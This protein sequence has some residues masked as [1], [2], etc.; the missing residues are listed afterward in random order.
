MKALLIIGLQ[1]SYLNKSEFDIK[2]LNLILQSAIRVLEYFR[3]NRLPVFHIKSEYSENED[4]FIENISELLPLENEIVIEKKEFNSFNQTNLDAKLQEFGVDDLVICGMMTDLTID[5]TVRCA[6]DLKY[7]VTLISDACIARDLE[8]KGIKFPGVLVNNVFLAVLENG[9]AKVIS[10][11]DYVDSQDET[12]ENPDANDTLENEKE[13]VVT[14]E[15][16][17]D[18]ESIDEEYV[19]YEYDE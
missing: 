5:A 1:N 14:I 9:Y 7:N 13:D 18:L 19:I 6:K 16:L 10:S 8:F 4:L 11:R 12:I 17:Q 3:M 15:E 2:K